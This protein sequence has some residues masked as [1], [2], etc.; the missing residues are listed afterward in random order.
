M[1]DKRRETPKMSDEPL[2]SRSYS[3]TTV[4][5]FPQGDVD[6]VESPSLQVVTPLWGTTT[7]ALRIKLKC[8]LTEPGKSPTEG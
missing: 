7:L 3:Y 8:A 2:F 6:E 1:P 4:F 5:P